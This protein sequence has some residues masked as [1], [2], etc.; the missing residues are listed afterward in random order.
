MST[1]DSQHKTRP[2]DPR[3]PSD[4][5]G[6]APWFNH[7]SAASVGIEIAVMF[8][9][10]TFGG[11]WL[12]DHVTHWAPWTTLL[13]M[14]FGAAAASMVLLRL[15]RQHGRAMAAKAEAEAAET[16]ARTAQRPSR[17]EARPHTNASPN[18][19][20]NALGTAATAT[21]GSATDSAATATS[22]DLWDMP[23]RLDGIDNLLDLQRS[24]TTLPD[25]TRIHPDER[26][27]VPKP[28]PRDAVVDHDEAD[29]HDDRDEASDSEQ[30]SER[31]DKGDP[32]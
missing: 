7:A 3:G 14:L 4:P 22:A 1:H 26:D 16:A 11:L 32:H 28:D 21:H 17:E 12:E 8:A 15:I 9:M 6:P 13:G 10:G 25:E 24:T 20:P 23:D 29:D 2:T 31:D 19:S 18:A 27:H 5:R 30:G